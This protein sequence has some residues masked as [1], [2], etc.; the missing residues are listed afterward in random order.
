[1]GSRSQGDDYCTDWIR[2]VMSMQFSCDATFHHA[3]LPWWIQC[4]NSNVTFFPVVKNFL[5]W[6][7]ISYFW[8][9]MLSHNLCTHAHTIN[10]TLHS[11]RLTEYDTHQTCYWCIQTGP[12]DQITIQWTPSL[13]VINNWSMQDHTAR[14]DGRYTSVSAQV[15]PAG[16][17][18]NLTAFD[19]ASCHVSV[20]CYKLVSDS[21]RETC[22]SLWLRRVLHC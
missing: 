3:S 9:R 4:S 10:C 19:M 8:H 2:N 5:N 22:Q 12:L 14:A 15:S 11:L 6:N 17:Q 16:Q 1:M 7:G 13:R 20:L 21:S 18:T